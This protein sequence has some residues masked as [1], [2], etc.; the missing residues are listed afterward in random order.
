MEANGSTICEDDMTKDF[1]DTN[2]PILR[3]WFIWIAVS[4]VLNLGWEIAHFP[5]YDVPSNQRSGGKTF[6]ILHCTAG[7]ALISTAF[8]LV[9]ALML[10][11]GAWFQKRTGLFLFILQ[12]MLYTI[13][14]EWRNALVEKNW[15]YSDVMPTLGGIGLS[16]LL[17]WVFVPWIT[18]RCLFALQKRNLRIFFNGEV[19]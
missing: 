19:K 14:S 11:N 6:A 1:L 12:T 4:T 13:Y 5:L 10:R 15:L 17:Q 7:D 16:P 3:P 2:K 8:Y 18:S 9:T